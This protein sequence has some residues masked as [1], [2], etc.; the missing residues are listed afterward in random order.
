MVQ[1]R[2]HKNRADKSACPTGSHEEI[3]SQNE[4]MRF[5]ALEHEMAARKISVWNVTHTIA[6]TL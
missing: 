4:T 3:A 5:K 2:E 6:T 1:K